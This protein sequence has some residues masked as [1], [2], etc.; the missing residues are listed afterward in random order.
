MIRCTFIRMRRF[1]RDTEGAALVE[2][3]LVLPVMLLLFSVTIEGARLMWSYQAAIAGVRDATRYV[4]RVVPGDICGT[5]SATAA[6]ASIMAWQD[7]VTDIVRNSAGGVPLFP[8]SII[9]DDVTPVVDCKPGAFHL[10]YTPVAT[11]TADM[12]ITWPFSGIFSL[13]GGVPPVTHL[14]VADTGRIFGA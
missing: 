5:S 12:T 10:A 1:A 6:Q 9:V 7:T 2:F 4:G 11:V 14:Q 13:F 8:A 3:G